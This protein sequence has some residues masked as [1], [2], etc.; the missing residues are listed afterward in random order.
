MMYFF[1]IH[2]K[3]SIAINVLAYNLHII[4]KELYS[5]EFTLQ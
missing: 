2:L 4:S 5:N 3:L 1:L